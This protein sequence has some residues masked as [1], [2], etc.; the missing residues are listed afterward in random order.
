VLTFGY[1]PEA[2]K[3]LLQEN[4][5]EIIEGIKIASDEKRVWKKRRK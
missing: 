1:S 5:I 3:E 4:D 2:I